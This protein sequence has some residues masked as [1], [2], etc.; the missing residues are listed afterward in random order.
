MRL[1]ARLLPQRARLALWLW[2]FTLRTKH[3]RQRVLRL[4]RATLAT[5][6]GTV[7]PRAR[8]SGLQR[9]DRIVY[10]NLPKR[11]DRRDGFLR[12]AERLGFVAESF[13]AIADAIPM[14][15]CAASHLALAK[16]T[17]ESGAQA[18]MVC[19]DDVRFSA[20]R[21]ELGLLVDRFLD[22][23]AAEVLC[24]DYRHHA[25]VAHS[26]LLLRSPKT[27]LA[28]CYVV[29]ASIVPLLVDVWERAVE[30]LGHRPDDSPD[31][32]WIELQGEHVFLIPIRRPANQEPGHS[33]IRG[34]YVAYERDAVGIREER[35]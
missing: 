28:G 5:A 1:L 21:R 25:A 13:E 7:R 6:L 27:T 17:V 30:S 34:H 19:E 23:P 4:P 35:A 14:R 33:D 29:K 22:D 32:A 12:E 16:Q 2:L 26:A 10:I 24:L 8:P 9:L 20:G 18:V 15:G 31:Y 11:S 3:L